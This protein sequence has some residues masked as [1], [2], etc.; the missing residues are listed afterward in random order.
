M[1][2]QGSTFKSISANDLLSKDSGIVP[3]TH[4]N[5]DNVIMI[6]TMKLINLLMPVAI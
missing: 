3:E 2:G 4:N 1:E 5:G 6:K